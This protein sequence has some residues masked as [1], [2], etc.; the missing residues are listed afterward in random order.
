LLVPWPTLR[1]SL[2]ACRPLLWDPPLAV[3]ARL[4]VPRA[5]FGP[6]S[7]LLHGDIL[8]IPDLFPMRLLIPFCR[9]RTRLCPPAEENGRKTFNVV[10]VRGA[11]LVCQAR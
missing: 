2:R 4:A 10:P 8:P 5:A 11:T 1:A 6:L 7:D 3:R 9:D